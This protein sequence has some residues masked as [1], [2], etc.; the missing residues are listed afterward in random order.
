ML[1]TPT[2]HIFEMYTVHHDATML[3]VELKSATYTLDDVSIPAV[4]AS[5]SRQASGAIHLSLVNTDPNQ[6]AR[7]LCALT[8]AE[9]KDIVQ[10]RVLT[11][12]TITAH[13]TFDQPEAV[14]PAAFN[15]W[16]KTDAGWEVTLP[17]KSVAVLEMR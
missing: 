6:P 3:P 10:G 5:A 16:K 17:P 2:Y 12:P 9:V 4:S 15:A 14:K 8:G 7:V 1:L 11:A 13:N